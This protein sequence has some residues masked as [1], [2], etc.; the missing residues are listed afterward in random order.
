MKTRNK[1]TGPIVLATSV[2]ALIALTLSAVSE[3][4][5]AVAPL[6]L[7]ATTLA[8]VEPRTPIS[9]V[10]YTIVAPGSYYLTGSLAAADSDG[11]IISADDVTVD[12][13]GFGLVG[14]RPFRGV[15]LNG[16]RRNVELRNG[17]IRGF[18]RGIY[19]QERANDGHRIIN[20]RVV[21]NEGAGIYLNGSF[22]LVKDCTVSGNADSGIFA[23]TTSIITGNNVYLNAGDGIWTFLGATVTHN[24]VNANDGAGIYVS[25]YCTVRDNT[26]VT[27]NLI[28]DPMLGGIRI[29]DDCFV[30]NNT[31][32]GNVRAGIFV[33]RSGNTLE[34]NLITD[35][36][37]GVFFNMGGNYYANNRFSGNGVHLANT[38]GN[39]R[40]TGNGSF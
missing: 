28:N 12:F 2:F 24:T 35:S 29:S 5:P 14:V 6:Q 17:S 19:A 7:A 36:Q 39:K 21:D 3:D 9:A 26:V 32:G 15:M 34:E 4:E 1:R 22:H 11:I 38:K 8:E 27:N 10:P 33:Q 18:G 20:M 23:Y 40:G 25:N 30:K 13:R 37:S 16:A 31:V